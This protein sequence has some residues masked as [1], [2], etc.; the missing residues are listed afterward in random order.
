[1]ISNELTALR[2]RISRLFDDA[3][4]PT[5]AAQLLNAAQTAWWSWHDY[6]PTGPGPYVVY[7]DT[8]DGTT[9][10]SSTP[11]GHEG[12]LTIS[13]N[14]TF[15]GTVIVNGSV[16]LSGT[17]T[18]NGLVYSLN[19]MSVSGNVTVNGGMVSENRRDASSVNIDTDYS[20]S[21]MMNYDCSKIRNLPFSSNWI[22]KPGN[23]LETAGY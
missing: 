5:R 23:Y 6:L 3:Q 9:F 1:M 15:N 18:F 13:S 21:I 12:S 17:P 14:G 10:T 19:D 4:P 8:T 2:R 7:I 11:P 22:V 16:N 20:G